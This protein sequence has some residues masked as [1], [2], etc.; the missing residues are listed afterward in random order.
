MIF[1]ATTLCGVA[2]A[3]EPRCSS[4]PRVLPVPAPRLVNKQ[5]IAV[6]PACQ[7][8]QSQGAVSRS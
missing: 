8:W 4:T 6:I 1:A 3:Y 7:D 2:R 5:E